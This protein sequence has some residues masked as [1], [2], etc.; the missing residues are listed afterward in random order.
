M[1]IVKLD[2]KN[3]DTAVKALNLGKVII[4]PT[5]TVY[6]FL[7]LA[8]NKKAVNKIY[9]IKNRPKSKPLPI[10]IKDLKMARSLAEISERQEKILKKCWPGK[11]T[12]VLNKKNSKKTIA[13]RIPKFNYLNDLLKRINKPLSQTSVNISGQESLRK[14]EDIKN[15]F[16]NYKILFLSVGDLKKS[17]P[18]KIL[19]LTKDKIELLRK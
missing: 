15:N 14:V 10:F 1:E 7:A 19:D 13:L 3:L 4:F 11:Y 12:F 9:K 6:G 8:D 2:K 18:S 16:N 17:Q 5:D